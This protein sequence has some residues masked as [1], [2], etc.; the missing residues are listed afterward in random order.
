MNTWVPCKR[1][2][3][4]T[5]AAAALLMPPPAMFCL[6]SACVAVPPSRGNIQ[7]GLQRNTRTRFCCRVLDDNKKLCLN[8]GTWPQGV[9]GTHPCSLGAC[10]GFRVY[11]LQETERTRCRGFANVMFKEPFNLPLSTIQARSSK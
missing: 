11:P 6:L 3:L 10:L 4:R 8:S 7:D 1:S 9:M 2:A 5:A